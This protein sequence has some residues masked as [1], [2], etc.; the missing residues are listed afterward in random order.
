[1]LN[2]QVCLI[3]SLVLAFIAMLGGYWPVDPNRWAW[4]GGFFPASFFFFLLYVYAA[5]SRF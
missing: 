4:R 5:H 3:I 1:M 2:A